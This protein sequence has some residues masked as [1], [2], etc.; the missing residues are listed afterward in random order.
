MNLVFS[1]GFASIQK[2]R[3]RMNDVSTNYAGYRNWHFALVASFA[4]KLS[5]E[6]TGSWN[7]PSQT[8]CTS[9]PFIPPWVFCVG[10]GFYTILPLEEVL[11]TKLPPSPNTASIEKVIWVQSIFFFNLSCK[12]SREVQNDGQNALPVSV[13]VFCVEYKWAFS[14]RALEHRSAW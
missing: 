13:S 9:L 5:A 2:L 11:S 10:I 1:L 3:I 7:S 4:G 6:K 12:L 8:L 14:H